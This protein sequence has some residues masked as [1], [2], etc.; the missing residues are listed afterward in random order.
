MAGSN[1]IAVKERLLEV[2]P[3]QLG[4]EGSWSYVGKAHAANREYFY[5]G[6]RAQGPMTAAAMAGGSRFTRSEDLDFE[7]GI[8]VFRPGEETTQA[9]ETDI[10]ALGRK[11]EEYLAG[12]WTLGGGI[13]GLLKVL[14]TGFQ[15]DS[16]VEDGNAFATLI[17]PLQLQSHV[18]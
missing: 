3:G 17:Y 12:N 15:L 9:A 16:S 1:I 10:V 5:F 18:R 11:V 2:L 4:I 8:E 6:D 13:N 7:L 14:I